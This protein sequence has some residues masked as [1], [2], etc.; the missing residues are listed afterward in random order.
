[1]P[2]RQ[3]VWAVH[4]PHVVYLIHH[5]QRVTVDDHV[6]QMGFV[7]K[8]QQPYEP[9]VFCVVVGMQF[10]SKEMYLMGV[11]VWAVQNPGTTAD[12]GIGNSARTVAV[13]G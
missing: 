11:D 5:Q 4:V 2:I 8:L 9:L 6:A 13:R 1:L 12:T 10:R 7:Q 3:K